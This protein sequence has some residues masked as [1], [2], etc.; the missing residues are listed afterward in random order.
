MQVLVNTACC[1]LML[2]A[3]LIQCI[4]FGPLRVSERQVSPDSN[5]EFLQTDF[6]L[7]EFCLFV[8]G[9]TGGIWKFPGQGLKLHHSCS[10]AR[11]LT[12]YATRELPLA[13]RFCFLKFG[14]ISHLKKT[15]TGTVRNSCIDFI[16][17]QSC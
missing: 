17:I 16:Q 6:Y 9:Y 11:S 2:V 15:C 1:V 8:L 12:F 5:D 4:V 3:K 7:Y 10:N 14:I 13:N